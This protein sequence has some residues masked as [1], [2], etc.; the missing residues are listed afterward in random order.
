MGVGVLV[1]YGLEGW[2]LV[3]GCTLVAP[4]PTCNTYKI[5]AYAISLL[6]RQLQLD[7]V[8]AVQSRSH[9]GLPQTQPPA[10]CPAACAHMHVNPFR[11]VRPATFRVV[12]VLG[13]DVTSAWLL[14]R[15]TLRRSHPKLSPTDTPAAIPHAPVR[16][17]NRCMITER[18]KGYYQ[19][20]GNHK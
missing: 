9:Q 20:F 13:G 8:T 16:P 15:R 11:D 14:L 2:R 6:V 10:A 19:D 7:H 1:G 3:S 5:I 18:P 17:H 12:C 4:G